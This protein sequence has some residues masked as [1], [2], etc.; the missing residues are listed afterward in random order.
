MCTPGIVG[1]SAYISKSCSPTLGQSFLEWNGV[2]V[3]VR[4]VMLHYGV[5][6]DIVWNHTIYQ[7][8]HW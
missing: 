4:T 6:V 2:K 7:A 8:Q 5:Q 1:P 3:G